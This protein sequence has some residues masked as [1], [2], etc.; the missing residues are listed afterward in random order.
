MSTWKP[1]AVFLLTVILIAVGLIYG[2]NHHTGAPNA[3]GFAVL[4]ILAVG[5]FRVFGRS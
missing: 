1:I 4:A 3:Y 2:T 5:G